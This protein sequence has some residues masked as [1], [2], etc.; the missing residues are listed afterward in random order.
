MGILELEK[1]NF[2]SCYYRFI[3]NVVLFFSFNLQGFLSMLV[4]SDILQVT[5]HFLFPQKQRESFKLFYRSAITLMLGTTLL[6]AS[7]VKATPQEAEF[8]RTVA[9]QYI[10]AQFIDKSDENTKIEVT[11]A[12]IDDRRDY[13]GKCEGYLTAQLKGTE[14]R[15][16]SQVIITCSRPEAPYSIVIPVKVKRLTRSLV[17]ARNLSRGAII[18]QQ[19]LAPVYI[20]EN[21]NLTTAVS[22]PNILVGSRLKREVKAGDQIR[23]NAFCVV[24]KNDKINIVAKNK[25]LQ[26]KLA[27]IALE[28]GTVNDS[29]RVKNTK[30]G[31]VISAV[32]VGPSEVQVV[33]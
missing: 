11:A 7:P 15:S 5:K 13:G 19:D 18:G 29:I 12:R 2:N 16:S 1:R 17:A 8:L 24:C 30:S 20:D 33:F 28:D 26:I 9:E 22:D 6:L 32:V 3:F 10:L 25:A 27:G 31:K 21:T 4:L 14:I 23:A